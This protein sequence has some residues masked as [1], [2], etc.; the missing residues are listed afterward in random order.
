VVT[1][2]RRLVVLVLAAVVVLAAAVVGVWFTQRQ[3]PVVVDATCPALLTNTSNASED[4]ADVVTWRGRTYVAVEDGPDWAQGDTAGAVTCSIG[5]MDNP[6][7]WRVAPGAW[8]D[9]TATRLPGGTV[10]HLV[11]DRALAADESGA[12]TLYCETDDTLEPHC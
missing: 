7:G 2:R 11:G 3:L 9:G 8:P 4:F 10:L 6:E 1:R 5:E 12:L